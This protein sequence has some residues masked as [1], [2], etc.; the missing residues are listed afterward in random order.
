VLAG[1]VG[2]LSVGVLAVGIGTILWL[3]NGSTAHTAVASR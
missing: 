3:T 2:A 1:G